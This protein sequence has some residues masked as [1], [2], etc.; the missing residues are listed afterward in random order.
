MVDL[1]G[2]F[3]AKLVDAL[4]CSASFNTA[5]IKNPTSNGMNGICYSDI[6]SGKLKKELGYE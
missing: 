2:S 4:A 3:V 5:K 6:W 1:C